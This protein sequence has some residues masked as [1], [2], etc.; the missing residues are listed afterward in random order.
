ML[1]LIA[2][3]SMTW[4]R[5]KTRYE[6]SVA[7]RGK[8]IIPREVRVVEAAP[9]GWGAQPSGPAAK[10]EPPPQ[11]TPTETKPVETAKPSTA[12]PTPPPS[13]PAP[14]A[15]TKAQKT[16]SKPPPA[17]AKTTKRVQVPRILKRRPD[18]R[19]RE[20]IVRSPEEAAE[21]LNRIDRALRP[22]SP[23]RGKQN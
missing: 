15:P 3:V 17:P 2:L 18:G 9:P 21:E 13:D 14:A 7:N 5:H 23:P 8:V 22:G 1:I 10:T 19:A 20:V 4:G 11:K 16:D 12:S 6:A